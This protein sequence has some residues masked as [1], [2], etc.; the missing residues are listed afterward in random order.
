MKRY[1]I[2]FSLTI[3][4]SYTQPDKKIYTFNTS[5]YNSITDTLPNICSTIPPDDMK[6]LSPFTQILTK[7]FPDPNN[8]E[9]Y[10]GCYYQFYTPT[11]KPQIAI[12]LIKW[13]TKKEAGDDFH[14]FFLSE[15]NASGQAPE[16]LYGIADSAYFSF[17]FNDT[18]KCDECG[19]VATV[20][21]FGIY[22]AFKGEYE[23]VTR[24][25]KKEAALK[26]LQALYNRIPGIAPSR[27]RN[28]K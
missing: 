2:L 6:E 17:G 8:F 11:E 22:I 15:W 10:S 3:I 1:G 18:T 21:D 16:R 19:L 4:F 23:K 26:I 25:R 12:R 20:K 28:M 5:E 14:N 7:V 24:A 9:T 27:I 13:G